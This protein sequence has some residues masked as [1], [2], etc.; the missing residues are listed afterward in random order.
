[1]KKDSPIIK[2]NQSIIQ[3]VFNFLLFI[4][5]SIIVFPLTFALGKQRNY[6][7]SDRFFEFLQELLNGDLSTLFSLDLNSLLIWGKIFLSLILGGYLVYL[8][9]YQRLIDK[10]RKQKT[11]ILV[12]LSIVFIFFYAIIIIYINPDIL[13]YFLN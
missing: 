10:L 3:S 7:H 13:N 9:G 5:S 2:E 8:K 6:K 4:V 12:F 11:G 1:M